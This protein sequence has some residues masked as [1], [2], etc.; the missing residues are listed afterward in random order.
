MGHARLNDPDIK[1]KYIAHV[2]IEKC[3]NFIN[4]Y[5]KN[6]DIINESIGGLRGGMLGTITGLNL[7]FVINLLKMANK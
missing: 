1:S 4:A 5:D 7:S 2:N 3:N 6:F